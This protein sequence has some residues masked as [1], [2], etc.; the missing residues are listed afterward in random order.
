MP[1]Q[2]LSLN[3]GK[4]TMNIPVKELEMKPSWGPDAQVLVQSKLAKRENTARGKRAFDILFSLVGM[5]IASPVM[6]T[7]ALLIKL[8]DP[9]GPIFFS[10][11]RVGKDGYPFKMYKFRSMVTDAEERLEQL[12]HKNEIK[13]AMFKMKEDPRVTRIGRWIRKTSIDE[14][15]QLWNVLRGEMSLVGP[16]PPVPREI[17]QYSDRDLQRLSVTPGC[18]GLW[19]VSGRNRLSF[20]EMVDLDLQYIETQSVWLDLRI[21]WRT[22][23]SI[24]QPKDAY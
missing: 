20:H 16:R 6:L 2:A 24:F 12:L 10:Q 8:E 18:T 21:I 14:L 11:T 5:L 1:R 17:L 9:R 3:K 15:P 7:V 22:V 4:F 19:Q 13:G 23:W